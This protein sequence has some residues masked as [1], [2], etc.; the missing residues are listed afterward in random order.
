MDRFYSLVTGQDDAFYQMCIKPPNVIEQV[1]SEMQTN[2]I[3]H[4]SVYAE[5]SDS[6]KSS[7][8][9]ALYMLSFKDYMG[10]SAEV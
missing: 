1:V 9:L 2:T 3:P 6:E 8:V 4:D 7:F 10:F 5:L